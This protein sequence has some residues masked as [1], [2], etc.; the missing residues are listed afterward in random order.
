MADIDARIS[1]LVKTVQ[2]LCVCF[3]KTV[4]IILAQLETL[5]T[6]FIVELLNHY[7]YSF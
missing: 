4:T 1:N 6:V 7:I 2:Y 5:N 3:M